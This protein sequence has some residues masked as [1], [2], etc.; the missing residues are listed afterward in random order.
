M[1]PRKYNRAA[2]VDS[3]RSISS[4]INSDIENKLLLSGDDDDT[5]QKIEDLSNKADM[6]INDHSV[7][8]IDPEPMNKSTS[9][10]ANKSPSK[11]VIGTGDAIMKVLLEM[12]GT[13]YTKK[14]V[15]R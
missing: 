9:L 6:L 7:M 3:Q 13:M 10:N 15:Y 5:T 2:S 1:K 14:M 11:Q 12:K 8:D 4:V